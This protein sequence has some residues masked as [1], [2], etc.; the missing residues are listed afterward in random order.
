MATTSVRRARLP[1][2]LCLAFAGSGCESLAYYGQA[3]RGQAALL[4]GARS[5]DRLLEDPALA[6]DRRAQLELARTLREFAERELALPAGDRYR[7]YV[8]LDREAV[9]FNVYAAPRYEMAPLLWCFPIAGCVS[10][11]GYFDRAAAER[12]AR[13]LAEQGYDVHVGGV[14]AY[15]TL[16]WFDDPLLSS[17]LERPPADLAEL[18]FHELAHSIAY[19]PG[20]TAFNESFAT[21]VGREG[22]RRWLDEEEDPA[23]RLAWETRGQEREGFIAFALDARARLAEA[24]DSARAAGADERT[25]EAVRAR[26]WADLR[27]RWLASRSP[28]AAPY[29][30]FFLA[31]PSNARLNTVAD[32]NQHVPAFA[33]L[34]EETGARFEPFF[35]RVRALASAPEVEREA[36]LDAARPDDG[37]DLAGVR[38]QR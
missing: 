36:F 2:L 15:S 14:A 35:D 28:D 23:A 17:F 32:Y 25:L 30:G 21:F 10:Y 37:P 3:V 38:A 11:R 8:E 5:V 13:A 1:V 7:R 29:D 22:V 9:L 33:A 6:A 16:G 4:L 26:E 24:F 34:F 18:L 27:R 12:K 20:D 19:V 31:V